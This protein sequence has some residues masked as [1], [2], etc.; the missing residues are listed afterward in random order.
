MKLIKLRQLGLLVIMLFASGS[1]FAQSKTVSSSVTGQKHISNSMTSISK[2]PG[3]T[4]YFE[5]FNAGGIPSNYILLNY[6]SLTPQGTYAAVFGDSAWT[7]LQWTGT[8]SPVA[9]STSWYTPAGTSNDWMIIPVTLPN[10]PTE[11]KWEAAASD[12]VPFNDGY[13]VYVAT[14]SDTASLVANGPVFT[15]AGENPSGAFVTRTVN[16]DSL[17]FSNQTIFI[18][19]RN[20]S[21]D[22]NL[23]WI[24]NILVAE[25]GTPTT[26]EVQIIHNSADLAAGLVDVFIDNTLAL[27]SVAFQT[28]TPFLQLPD[29]FNLKISPV[30]AGTGAAVYDEDVELVAGQRYI[31]VA[32]GIVSGSGYN[33]APAFEIYGIDNARTSANL[34]GN[35]DVLVF[36][37]STDAPTVTVNE[38]TLPTTLIDTISYGNFNA[39]YAEL[40]TADYILSVTDSANITLYYSAPLQTLGLADAAL[41]V[42]ASGF[43]DPSQN[44]NGAGFGLYAVLPSGGAFIPLPLLEQPKA[45]IIHNSADA[46]AANVDIFVDGA[47]AVPGVAFRSAT[48]Y[49]S[50]PHNFNL[51]IAPAGSGIGASVFNAPISLMPGESYV[52]IANGILSPSGYNPA[53]AFGLDVFATGREAA[54]QSGNTDVLIYHGSTDAPTVDVNETSVPAGPL[55]TGLS[56]SDFAPDYLELATA[57]YVVQVTDGAAVD[58]EYQAPLSTLSL[59]DSAIVV[60]AS[61]FVD[62]TQNSNGPGFGLWAALANG[63]ALVELPVVVG[64]DNI[65]LTSKVNLY[66]NPAN[67]VLNL[68]LGDLQAET[69]RLVNIL[70]QEIRTFEVN[71]M[72]TQSLDISGIQSGTYFLQI[73]TSNEIGSLPVVIE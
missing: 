35:T 32:A 41:V 42:V 39:G 46:A 38:L 36:H 19:F 8:T 43:V 45:Q 68:E 52:V 48:G 53:P 29:S 50:L 25:T 3:D 9:T 33:P 27:D 62:P 17:G 12:G 2:A 5:D 58:I 71:G 21:S 30:G 37:G 54:S 70:G 57:D 6:D 11:L 1:L 64:L 63:G 10:A 59:T 40:P 60:L 23:L 51:D 7:V 56:Y 24:D 47:N 22:R 13:D 4:V 15:T 66:P 20:A 69:V 28:A 73:S 44:S 67:S 55:A 14:T 34:S 26:A 72:S 16:L 61:G 18:A 65:N 49:L 31:A